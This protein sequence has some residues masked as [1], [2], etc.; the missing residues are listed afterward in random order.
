MPTIQPSN[1]TIRVGCIGLSS[2]GWGVHILVPALL[3]GTN[4]QTYR[5]AA[6]GGRTIESAK[7]TAESYSKLV[8]Y[9]V[10]GIG[11]ADCS[12]QMANDPDID[13]V[14]V[15]VQTP[16]HKEVIT[17]VIAA[18]K[19]FMLEWPIGGDHATE[20]AD[21]VRAKNIRHMIGLHNPHIKALQKVSFAL[22]YLH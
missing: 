14:I 9:E 18:G 2:I 15:S 20:I 6:V 5:L 7:A 4:A 13:F 17:P 8:G 19:A 1:H 12:E 16:Y 22:T 3:N 21:M 11:G 10:R